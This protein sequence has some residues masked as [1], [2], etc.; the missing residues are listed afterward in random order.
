M[1]LI[2]LKNHLEADKANFDYSEEAEGILIK[3]KRFGTKILCSPEAVAQYDWPTIKN[4]S[5]CG[6]DVNHIT[7]VTGYFTIVEGWNKGKLA[8]LDDRYHG[9]VSA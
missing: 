8:E 1:D 7:R 4:F 3:N 5:V 9:E 6:R 2:E